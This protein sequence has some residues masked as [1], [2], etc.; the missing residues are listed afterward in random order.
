MLCVQIV[1]NTHTRYLKAQNWL[2]AYVHRN[3]RDRM[4]VR[5]RHACAIPDMA[6]LA[7]A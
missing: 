5:S 3:Q 2:H 1:Q 7:A 6:C 4:G